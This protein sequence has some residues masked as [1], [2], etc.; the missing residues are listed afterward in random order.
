ME[1]T[2][3]DLS[4]SLSHFEAEGGC[5]FAIAGQ[6]ERQCP[7]L[8]QA[9]QLPILGRRTVNE[10]GTRDWITWG[11]CWKLADEVARADGRTSEDLL[12]VAKELLLF[13]LRVDKLARARR[14]ALKIRLS[15]SESSARSCFLYSSMVNQ[16]DSALSARSMCFW[17]SSNNF[18]RSSNSDLTFSSCEFCAAD[19]AS[20]SVSP[21]FRL[22]L[23]WSS[24]AFR[25]NLWGSECFSF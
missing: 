25:L 15:S 9:K 16:P 24:L 14:S 7:G 18:S 8:P 1:L 5:C 12:L 3:P 20:T 13:F 21:N 23:Y 11:C 19:L 10:E 17:R 4:W 6:V 2:T 22:N